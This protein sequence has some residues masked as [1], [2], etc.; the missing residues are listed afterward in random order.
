[1]S[2]VTAY[3]K[4][5]F[6]RFFFPE[7]VTVEVVST[8]PARS[9]RSVHSFPD[10]INANFSSHSTDAFLKLKRSYD[11]TDDVPVVLRR[12]GKLEAKRVDSLEVSFTYF[13]FYP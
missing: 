4:C 10:D 3:I 2:I 13:M 5:T 1:M 8:S 9:K 11:V 6:N 7:N 12:S